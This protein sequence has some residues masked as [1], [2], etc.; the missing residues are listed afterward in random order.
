[1]VDGQMAL[2]D[3]R[4]STMADTNHTSHALYP[5]FCPFLPHRGTYLLKG[6]GPINRAA[7]RISLLL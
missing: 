2:I 1:L 7:Q 6:V 5:L 3:G 4:T